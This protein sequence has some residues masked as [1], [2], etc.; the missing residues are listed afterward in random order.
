[1]ARTAPTTSYKRLLLIAESA[2]FAKE[3][4]DVRNPYI[5]KIGND[6]KRNRKR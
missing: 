6:D 4:T 2:E 5:S 1:M 3:S